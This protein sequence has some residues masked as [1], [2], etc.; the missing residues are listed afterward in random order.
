MSR[1]E[2]IRDS[3]TGGLQRAGSAVGLE[4]KTS[5]Q[6]SSALDELSDLCPSLSY[7]QRIIGFAVCFGT[8][9]LIT[10]LSFGMFV[11]LVEGDPV[12]FVLIYTFGNILS[13]CSSGF[14]VGPKRQFKNMFDRQR[15]WTSVVYLATLLTTLVVCFIPMDGSAKLSILVL[16]LLIQL[17][18]SLWYSL[19]YI[20]FARKAAKKFM[21]SAVG[22]DDQV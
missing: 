3:V 9:Y 11:E 22:L 4:T 14:L 8:G 16:L 6:D 13:L 18:S 12:P 7:Q 1:L 10:F 5:S 15:K 21:K 20:P 17:C 19:S 2:S